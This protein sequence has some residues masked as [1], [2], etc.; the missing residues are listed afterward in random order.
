MKKDRIIFVVGLGMLVFG[1][2]LN[3]FGIKNVNDYESFVSECNDHF[4]RQFDLYC[5][6]ESYEPSPFYY[7]AVKNFT[8]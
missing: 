6:D 3:V 2:A 4:E 8:T 7:E 5:V 1:L